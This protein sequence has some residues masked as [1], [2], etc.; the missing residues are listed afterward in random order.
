MDRKT[1]RLLKKVEK[2][3]VRRSLHEGQVL[4]KEDLL[5][6]KVQILPNFFRITLGVGA[7]VAAVCSYLNWNWEDPEMSVLLAVVSLFLFL[8]AIFGIRRTLSRI[9]EN[10]DAESASELL[11]AAVDGVVSAV[12]AM[13]DGV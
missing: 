7:V 1:E 6:M 9:L 8:F 13:F 5:A 12:G 11:E 2:T 3:G 10:M 4:D